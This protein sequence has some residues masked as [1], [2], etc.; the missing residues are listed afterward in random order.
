MLKYK[1]INSRKC[2]SR[3]DP[4]TYSKG[5]FFYFNTMRINVE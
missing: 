4:F 2:F 1:E 3:L 5:V